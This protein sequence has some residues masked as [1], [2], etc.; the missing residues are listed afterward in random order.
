[1][2]N[3]RHTGELDLFRVYLDEVG[4][5]RAVAERASGRGAR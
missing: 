4:G 1:M 5:I 2:T 3:E